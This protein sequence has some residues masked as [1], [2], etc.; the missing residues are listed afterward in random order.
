M[1]GVQ[2]C[3]LPILNT[4]LSGNPLSIVQ[5]VPSGT[6]ANPGNAVSYIN[7]D[8]LS[9]QLS[10]ISG[11]KFNTLVT[12]STVDI[13]P[14]A[15]PGV[16]NVNEGIS[17]KLTFMD[18]IPLFARG[19]LGNQV[20]SSTAETVNF[21]FFKGISAQLFALQNVDV[22]L[23]LINGFGADV[24]TSGI[25][26]ISI[27]STNGNTVTL[28][29]TGVNSA[30]NLNRALFNPNFSN[31][32]TPSLKQ[33]PLN[34][35]NSNI[36]QFIENLPDKISYSAT[37]QI[38]PFGN[39]SG[40]NDFI[41]YGNGLRADLEMNIPLAFSASELTLKDTADF[42]LGNVSMIENINSGK[43]NVRV[44]N[45]FPFSTGI[46]AYLL[47]DQ[48]MLLDSLFSLPGIANAG[49]VNSN[50]VVIQPTLTILEI[51]LNQEKISHLQSAKKII[52]KAVL[53]TV[54]QPQIVK[55][56]QHYRMDFVLTADLNYS[57]NK[58]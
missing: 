14:N 57:V 33:I 55:L 39:I 49:V 32:V 53:N 2:T 24:S 20:F 19:Y 12:K 13:S 37:T 36:K 6:L 8:G 16:I 29:G 45:G 10:G 48:G 3:A 30:Y 9:M 25:Q 50:L 44:N 34:G 23:K 40:N 38:N 28:S 56:Y 42:N 26:F 41:Y 22:N 47:S 43:L 17:I 52:F 46:Q 7:I 31:P 54:S 1:T 18:V 27:N 11:N 15:N 35:T 5:Q 58:P 51:P 21:D 4:D